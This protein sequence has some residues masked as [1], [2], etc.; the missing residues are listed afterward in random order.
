M[1]DRNKNGIDDSRENGAYA[2]GQR[3]AHPMFPWLKGRGKSTPT[4]TR[5]PERTTNPVS[6]SEFVNVPVQQGL[7]FLGDLFSGF[8]RN[9]RDSYGTGVGDQIFGSVGKG[10]YGDK[11]QNDPRVD[12]TIGGY[13]LDRA[14]P[15]NSAPKNIESQVQRG[16][17]ALLGNSHANLGPSYG[18]DNSRGRTGSEAPVDDQSFASTLAEAIAMLR[19]Q[20]FGGGGPSLIDYD[21]L[22]GNARSQ[23]SEG[24][25]NLNAIYS[26]LASSI[27][28][29]A[30]GVGQ[31]YDQAVANQ[32]KI[33]GEEAQAI[34]QA[35]QS[36]DDM[37]SQQAKALGI[38]EAVAN[39][40]NSGIGA[41]EMQDAL[42]DNAAAQQTAQTQLNTNRGSALD[43]NTSVKQAAQQEGA[44]QRAALQAQLNS[45]LAQLDMQEQEANAAARSSYDNGLQS[46]G[47]S[48][49][50]W[51]HE[52]NRSDSR[53][54]D[55]LAMSAQQ[56]ANE[57]YL[58]ELEAGGQTARPSFNQAGVQYLMELLGYSD[59]SQ[60][61]RWVQENPAGASGLL[62]QMPTG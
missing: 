18:I 22:R 8:Q 57:R 35:Y 11:N 37:M 39:Q 46:A 16:A 61:Q 26:A 53:Y 32:G 17:A 24:D 27:G 40:I 14:F 47:L 6:L 2:P 42:T 4:L 34:Q 36:G 60:F 44:Q 54:Q 28:A 19:E 5:V 3:V 15:T 56:M 12:E 7:N 59:P 23:F 58:A 9:K 48:L 30:A 38:E 52:N 21:P 25:A 55:E 10:Y 51:M 41:G 20:G 13:F 31:S 33:S 43:Y 50:Q 45:V 29:D 62:K 49:A 1:A